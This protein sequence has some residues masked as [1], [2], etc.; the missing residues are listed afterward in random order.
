MEFGS[1][2]NIEAGLG[3]KLQNNFFS[4]ATLGYFIRSDVQTVSLNGESSKQ[5][6]ELNRLAFSIQGVYLL[7]ISNNM[8]LD[9]RGG[10]A[11][12]IPQKGILYSQNNERQLSYNPSLGPFVGFGANVEKKWLTL[13]LGLRYRYQR[14][15]LESTNNANEVIDPSIASANL[16][17]IDISLGFIIAF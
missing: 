4:E 11:Y 1:A 9:F 13:Q 3:F 5:G 15:Q 6:Y 10:L 17:A 7:E 8:Y 16:S 2:I 12:Y 14:H